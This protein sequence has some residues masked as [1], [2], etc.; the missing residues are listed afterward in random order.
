MWLPGTGRFLL[1]E[2]LIAHYAELV[3]KN[4]EIMSRCIFRVTRNAD[5][6]MDEGLYDHDVDFRDIMSDLVKKR[7]KLQPVRLEF[8]GTPD[9]SISS[10]IAKT[11]KVKDNFIFCQSA[12]LTMG[13]LCAGEKA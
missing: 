6:T 1:T 3:F 11:L 7:K 9:P 4:F 10:I 12:P 5:I 8:S 13:F 2:E